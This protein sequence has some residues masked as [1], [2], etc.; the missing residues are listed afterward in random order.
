MLRSTPSPPQM[1]TT[2]FQ[3]TVSHELTHSERLD[4]LKVDMGLRKAPLILMT[5]LSF[6]AATGLSRCGSDPWDLQSPVASSISSGWLSPRP[7]SIG[8][9]RAC[10]GISSGTNMCVDTAPCAVG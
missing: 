5:T 2:K 9:L 10:F 8:F 7:A 6:N 4:F 1:G 3:L